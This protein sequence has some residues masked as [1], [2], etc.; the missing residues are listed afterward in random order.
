[1]S[2]ERPTSLITGAS[3][4]IGAA[5]ARALAER[6]HDLILTAQ[7]DDRLVAIGAELAGRGTSVTILPADLAVPGTVER[8]CAEIAA[9]GLAVDW[10][11][12][13]AGYA[14]PGA[15]EAKPWEAHIAYTR[16]MMEAP[17][18]FVW[19]LLPGMRER[20]F[21][22]IINVASLAAF[23]PGLAGHTLYPAAKAYL[24][25]FSQ[26]LAFENRDRDIRICAL[27]PGF[28]R[29]DMHGTAGTQTFIDRLPA[30]LLQSADAVAAEGLAAIDAGR[31]VHV[32]GWANR[33]NTALLKLL[34]DAVALHFAARDAR[35]FRKA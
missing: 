28:T 30:Y 6:G 12:N 24:L 5:F 11:I 7:D 8:L 19:R 17:T 35:G 34:P 32:S 20:G 13:N 25:K 22:R 3:A 21:G 23:F 33:I 31:I 15:F 1:M 10:L 14:L 16:V 2:R 29:T 18:E 27:C 4:G 9:R 26:S